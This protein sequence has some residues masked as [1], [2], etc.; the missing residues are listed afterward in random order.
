VVRRDDRDLRGRVPRRRQPTRAQSGFGGDE[1]RWEAARRP[2]A[3]A[4][5]RD[6]T[7]L[8]VGCASGQLLESLVE[9]T[10]FQIEPY[11]LDLAPALVEL[12]R[13]RLP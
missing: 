6:G 7:F 1:A 12:A 4:I 2:I 8:D 10:P 9:W 5:D 3:D 11:G 13:R